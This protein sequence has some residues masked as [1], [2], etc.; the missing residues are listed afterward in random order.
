MLLYT[1][2]LGDGPFKPGVR[3]QVPMGAPK[4]YMTEVNKNK[5]IT[6]C[7]WISTEEAILL[8]ESSVHSTCLTE[9]KWTKYMEYIVHWERSPSGYAS[10]EMDVPKD[11]L[12]LN[13]KNINY[14]EKTL[15]KF[16]KPI[17]KKIIIWI[18]IE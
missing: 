10:F 4:I 15:L 5:T 6:K 8:I 16:V 11:N 7:E 9:G 18:D 2:W 3:V 17:E 14:S 1:N 12:K 13:I